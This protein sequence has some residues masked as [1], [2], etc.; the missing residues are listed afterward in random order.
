MYDAILAQLLEA[1]EALQ[2][3]DFDH[4]AS[5]WRAVASRLVALMDDEDRS[6]TPRI[7]AVHLRD[8]HAIL[9]E[10]R[11]LRR[12]LTEL[13]EAVARRTL[14]LEEARSFRDEVRAHAHH[15]DEILRNMPGGSEPP[16]PG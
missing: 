12:R 8:A 7:A 14:R 2:A 3:G 5:V 10:H 13:D 6:V 1:L 11:F 16:P 15:E 4:A 9:Q